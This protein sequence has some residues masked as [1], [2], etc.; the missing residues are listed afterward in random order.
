MPSNPHIDSRPTFDPD[1]IHESKIKE[2]YDYREL[3]KRYIHN[4]TECEGV[5]FISGGFLSE[6]DEHQLTI[7]AKELNK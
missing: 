5:D 1:Y 7:L 4:V 6:E 2:P 3:L